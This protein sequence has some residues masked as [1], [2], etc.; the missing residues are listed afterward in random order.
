[1]KIQ[2]FNIMDIYPDTD[3]PRKYFDEEALERL[4]V[5]LKENGLEQPLILRK[6]NGKHIIVDGERRW[7]AAQKAGL[8]TVDC[9]VTDKDDILEQQLRSDC[10]KEGLTVDELDKA[11]YKYY[12]HKGIINVT[13]NKNSVGR[14]I[15]GEKSLDEI[16]KTIGK[17]ILRVRK[18]IDRFEFKRENKEFTRQIEKKHNP[19][20]KPFSKVNSTIAMTDKLKNKPEV[21]KAV[22]AKILDDRAN[23][24]YGIDNETIK[25]K[26]DLIDK[27]NVETAEDVETILNDV[28]Q[29]QDPIKELKKDPRY[30]LQNQY[31]E[32]NR[33]VEKVEALD[34]ESV[35]EHLTDGTLQKFIKSSE[36]FTK[37][38][39]SLEAE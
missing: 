9:V 15:N 37:Y 17:S 10:L 6:E 23:K 11:I 33:F 25:Q 30:I 31:F 18:A 32:Y 7:R 19:E 28:A 39:K 4:V 34:F 35:K 5:S 27:R 3:Q 26:I 16:S 38:L 13:S 29:R 8:K 1:M 12:E 20:N 24:K 22:I 21:R 14:P 2:Q 36:D